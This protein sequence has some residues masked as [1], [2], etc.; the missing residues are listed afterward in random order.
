[1]ESIN[2]RQKK[3]SLTIAKV[4][5]FQNSANFDCRYWNRKRF[6]PKRLQEKTNFSMLITITSVI[7]STHNK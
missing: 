3:T 7:F 6:F 4:H 1:M 5:I 2:E